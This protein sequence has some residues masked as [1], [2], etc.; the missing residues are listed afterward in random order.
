MGVKT[1]LKNFNPGQSIKDRLTR[2]LEVYNPKVWRERG[3]GWTLGLFVVTYLV[4]V[5]VLGMLWS[6]SPETF[7]V[8]A[9]ALATVGG[10]ESRLVTGAYT[11]ATAIRIGQTLLEKP[12]GFLSNDIFP[13][14]VYLDNI[15]NWEFG[16]LTE[17]RD[18]TNALRNE[19][20]RAQSQSGEDPDL[21]LAQPQ[22]NYNTES[23]MLPSSESEYRRGIQALESYLNRLT[24]RE[25]QFFARSDNLILYLQ[26]V[27]RR[28]G[29]L[30]HRLS[31][32]VSEDAVETDQGDEA[33]A[34]S[35]N[36]A[37]GQSL[38]TSRTPWSQI[39][40]VFF[41]A[42][43][44]TWA[45]LHVLQGLSLD[46]EPM[47]KSKNALVS[48]NQIIFKLQETQKPI[49]SPLILNGTGFGPMANHSLVMASYI[50][51]ANAAVIDLR[52]LLEQG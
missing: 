50:A 6:R 14:G 5:V 32:A 33:A 49:W 43:G 11:A 48:V 13:P 24:R 15:P 12:G 9:N 3:M 41:E 20:T 45:L 35:A 22:F 40:D 21:L 30:A 17:L 29:S 37:G 1:S 36:P 51:R 42:R 19:L 25:A 26:V 27:E 18:I 8:R 16:A 10:D 47:L 4:V 39:D 34:R 52:R 2:L 38:I 7:D 28:L 31:Q 44:Y 23:W 46:F